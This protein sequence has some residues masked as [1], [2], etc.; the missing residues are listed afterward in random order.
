MA[1]PGP[2][3]SI[4]QVFVGA[5]IPQ[6]LTD[7]ILSEYSECK[8]R[9]HWGDHRPAAINGGRFCE[10]VV[11]AIQHLGS[12]PT[13]PL[14]KPLQVET[15]LKQIENDISLDE[16]LRLHIPRA[17]RLVYGV[18]NSRDA[19][20][21]KGGLDTSYQDASLVVGVIDWV[22]AELIRVVHKVPQAVAQAIVDGIVT[23]QVPVISEYN[24]KPVLLVDASHVDRV[25][26]LLYWANRPSVA[27]AELR[28]WLPASA[29]KNL[30]RTL[31]SAKA[32]HFVHVDGDEVFLTHVG[33]RHIEQTGLLEPTSPATGVKK[34]AA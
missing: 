6:D 17:L 15:A 25:L 26:A 19:G 1:I 28:K 21:L 12:S 29:A 7:A 4:Q 30:G 8:S 20:H 5:G 27:K 13:V 24:G 18:R 22:L 31:R 2:G 16:A 9:Y 32:K 34:S 3:A 23:K 11:R 14:S 10:A 33:R